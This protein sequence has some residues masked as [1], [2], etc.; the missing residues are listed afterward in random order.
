MGGVG[1]AAACVLAGLGDSQTLNLLGTMFE[2]EPSGIGAYAMSLATN[3]LATLLVAY[4][5]WFVL[6]LV[7]VCLIYN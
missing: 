5:A 3:L 1:A 2:R 4:K 6:R 7:R